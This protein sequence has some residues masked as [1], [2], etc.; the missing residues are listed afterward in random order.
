[1]LVIGGWQTGFS[2]QDRQDFSSRSH[3]HQPWGLPSHLSNWLFC[4]DSL[5]PCNTDVKSARNFNSTFPVCLCIVL[6]HRDKFIFNLYYNWY[7]CCCHYCC[8]LPSQLLAISSCTSHIC[9]KYP[10]HIHTSLTK[11]C[12]RGNYY[13]IFTVYFLTNHKFHTNEMDY[14]FF[15]T[16]L[17]FNPYICFKS[18]RVIFRGARSL[19]LLCIHCCLVLCF[20]SHIVKSSKV[21]VDYEPPEDDPVRVE[22]YV[23]V[24]E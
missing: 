19:H 15:L 12:G 6:R 18:Y 14:V 23:G 13:I 11:K 5:P 21:N 1:M 2:H 7:Y 17:F 4:Q 20:V 16:F 3:P 8:P 24:E 9:L 22:T 10:K